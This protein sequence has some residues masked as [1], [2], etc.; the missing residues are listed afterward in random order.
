M[1]PTTW[2]VLCLGTPGTPKQEA[3]DNLDL[4]GMI[5]INGEW[6]DMPDA[7]GLWLRVFKD[8]AVKSIIRIR[9]V[10]DGLRTWY[11]LVREDNVTVEVKPFPGQKYLGPLNL[12]E[13]K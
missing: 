5:K 7:P 13:F 3:A 4:S 8:G 9:Y 12:P 6:Q 10:C 2:G 11:E 1:R